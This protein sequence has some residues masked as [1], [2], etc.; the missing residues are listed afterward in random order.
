MNQSRP[1]PRRNGPATACGRRRPPD[2]HQI[3]RAGQ[4]KAWTP[5]R[6]VQNAPHPAPEHAG[7]FAVPLFTCIPAGLDPY[8][9]RCLQGAGLE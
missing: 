8:V 9:V 2:R 1:A 6:Q 3:I 4:A 7:R 5:A